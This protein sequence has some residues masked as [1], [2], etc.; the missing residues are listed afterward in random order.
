MERSCSTR[1]PRRRWSWSRPCWTIAGRSRSKPKRLFLRLQALPGF[2]VSLQRLHVLADAGRVLRREDSDGEPQ[3]PAELVI[4]L[5]D[6]PGGAVLSL[7]VGVRPGAPQR[8][9]D[10]P[11]RALLGLFVDIL[12]D[13]ELLLVAAEVQ[14]VPVARP[15][16]WRSA[17]ELL[18]SVEVGRPLRCVG[19]FLSDD[20]PHAFDRG[21]DLY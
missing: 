3:Q 19:H 20:R 2:H 8:P 11:A 7:R 1:G 14:V 16:A 21:V 4:H 10:E 18:D 5:I 17:V 13:L 9:F 6:Q 12:L 15:S